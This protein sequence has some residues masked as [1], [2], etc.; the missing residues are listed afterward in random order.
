MA[1]LEENDIYCCVIIVVNHCNKTFNI[2]NSHKDIILFNGIKDL[3]I[4]LS[5]REAYCNGYYDRKQEETNN[6]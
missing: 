6:D 5:M 4:A 1:K 3:E 2:Y